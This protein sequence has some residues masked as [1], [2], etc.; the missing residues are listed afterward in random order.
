[1]KNSIPLF[2]LILTLG[3]SNCFSQQNI[4]AQNPAVSFQVFYDELSPY[5]TWV[6]NPDYGYVWSPNVGPD[7]VP[8]A[9]NG[10]WI[11]TEAGWTWLSDYAWGWAPF[12]YGRWFNDPNYGP[13]WIPDTVWGPGWVSWRSSDY[14]YGWAP[15][16]P[17]IAMGYSRPYSVPYNNWT[18]ILGNR[19]GTANM[20][21]YYL[22]HSNNRNIINHSV[23]INNGRG[24]GNHYN[25]PDRREVEGRIGNR[26][27]PIDIRERNM[28]GQ[29]MENNQFQIYRPQMQ[30]NNAQGRAPVPNQFRDRNEGN[31][32]NQRTNQ[33]RNNPPMQPQPNRPFPRNDRNEVPQRSNQPNNPPPSNQN[34]P[35]RPNNEQRPGQPRPNNNPGRNNQP[36]RA[37]RP[38]NQNQ[39][40]RPQNGGRKRN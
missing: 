35:Q 9:T 17:S 13:M 3:L 30:R 8:Y 34:R 24:G 28:P 31:F 37:E 38:S 4:F 16:G 12:H 6:D 23:V 27:A 2:A 22:N 10:H 7:F 39:P 21:R 14:Y 25:G 1:M 18:F 11:Y 32:P 19:F 20:N 40:A 36:Q 33:N 26:I 5:G 15:M 29:H